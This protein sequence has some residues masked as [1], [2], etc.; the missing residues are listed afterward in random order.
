M[1]AAHTVPQVL[2]DP[3]D[4]HRISAGNGITDNDALAQSE[5]AAEE[6]VA[7]QLRSQPA[8]IICALNLGL[9]LLH[10][11]STALHY[12]RWAIYREASHHADTG[13]RTNVQP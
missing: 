1:K 10:T 2:D 9:C 5:I 7:E 12:L 4:A 8:D 6:A 13:H 3:V 11:R